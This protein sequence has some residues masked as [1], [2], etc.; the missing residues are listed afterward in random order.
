MAQWETIS[1]EEEWETVTTQKPV[2]D[3]LTEQTNKA[4]LEAVGQAI[5]EPVKEAASAVGQAVETGWQALPEPVK[6]PLRSTG[7]F[8]LDALDY[9]NRPFQAVAVGAK[10]LLQAAKEEQK[11]TDVFELQALGRAIK[12]KEGLLTAVVEGAERGL[13]GKERASFQEVL[14]DEYRK[15]NP[16]KSALIGF[17]GDAVVDPLKAQTV[18]APFKVAKE[19]I[20]AIP[21]S[22]SIATRLTDYELFRAFNVTTGDVDKARNL[23]NSYRYLRDKAKFEGVRDAKQLNKQIKTLS[24]ESGIPVNELKAKIVHDVETGDLSS[25][26]IGAL[27]KQIIDRNRQILEQQKAAGVEIGDLGETYMPHILSK[28][29]DEV[30]NKPDKKKNFIGTRPSAK[31]PSAMKREIESTVAEINAKNLYGTTNFFIDDPAILLGTAEFRAANAIA[32]K[33]F[34]NDIQELGVDAKNAPANYV[35]IPEVPNVKFDRVVA[36]LVNRS[37]RAL[38]NTEEIN[39]VLK[40]YDGAQNWWKMWSLGVRPAY[41]A[42]NVMGNVWNNYLGGLDNPVRYGEAAIFQA[43]LARNKLDGTVVG[44]PTQEL[45]DEMSKRGIFGEGQY[46]GGEFTRVLERELGGIKPTDIITPGT[47]NVALRA[48]FKVGQTLEDN[49]RIALFLDQIKKGKS[50]D[51]AGKHVQKYLFDYGD[52]S[53]FEQNVMKRIMPFYTW[54]RKNIPLQLQAIAEHPD[55]LSK[56]GLLKS[57]IQQA[58]GMET[59]PDPSEM[60]D[61]LIDRAPIYLGEDQE[62]GIVSAVALENLVPFFDLGPFTRFLNTPT[63]PKGLLEAGLQGPLESFAASVSPFIK[64]PLEYL[65]NYDTFKKQE[66]AEFEGQQADLL[67]VEMPVHLAKLLSNIVVLSEIDRLNPGFVFGKREID[68]ATGD[69]VKEPSI[70]G[71][72][73][74]SRQDLPEGQRT[75]LAGLTGLRIIDVNKGQEAINRALQIERDVRAIESKIRSGARNEKSRDMNQAEEAID[76]FLDELDRLEQETRDRMK[77]RGR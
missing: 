14:S 5:P 63:V 29:A 36:K 72:E 54:S 38:T 35:T 48:G 41:H 25:G 67:G 76:K 53:P 39:K 49:A 45:Y 6:A 42:K 68:P 69:I 18:A 40:V 32:G 37:Y 10:P 57:N 24:K 8:L 77:E 60:P 51:E 66:I 47:R 16:V 1:K 71:V 28:D 2:V 56:L 73:R 52:V 4:A 50:Y 74:A 7:N 64:A 43:K 55:K 13:T 9:I 59:I 61:Y 33:R 58:A 31:N 23:Y 44:K 70:F 62:T 21:G 27:E 20:S 34:L 19:A 15:A 46:G 30:L 26:E 22:V 12:N 3:P 11:P 75:A 17:A 65:S